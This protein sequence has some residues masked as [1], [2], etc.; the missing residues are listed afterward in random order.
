MAS[1][2]LAKR[3]LTVGICTSLMT[4]GSAVAL[5]GGAQAHTSPF[6]GAEPGTVPFDFSA[7]FYNEHGVN[8]DGLTLLVTERA[9]GLAVIEDYSPDPSRSNV[10]ILATNAGYDAGG[11]LLYYPDPPA[12]M[13][14][15]S[16]VPPGTNPSQDE[17]DLYLRA[18]DI[19]DEFNVYIFPF[20][21]GAPFVPAPTNRR[22]DNIFDTGLGYLTD[23]P[24][25]LWTINFVRYTDE[26]VTGV[27]LSSEQAELMVE[28]A[29]RNGLDEDGTPILR[30]VHEVTTMLEAGLVTSET[31]IKTH[32]GDVFDPVNDHPSKNTPPWVV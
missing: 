16:F 20:R 8:P 29:N 17:I 5:S 32:L 4:L 26:A 19:A 7:D 22:Q 1:Q 3:F 28:M 27:G 10:R 31:R 30:R 18:R 25:G 21:D 15:G 12:F 6:Y 24:L 14:P 2:S 23:N 11:A 13:T 9:E